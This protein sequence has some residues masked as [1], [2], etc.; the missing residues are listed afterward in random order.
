MPMLS[1]LPRTLMM[2]IAFVALQVS[3]LGATPACALWDHQ[4]MASVTSS[5]GARRSGA[6]ADDASVGVMAA[7]D[8]FAGPSRELAVA[9]TPD[10]K[11]PCEHGTAPERCAVM[12]SCAAFIAAQSASPDEPP[13]PATR[14]ASAIML[15][16]V[17]AAL[18]PELPPPRA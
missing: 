7:N 18:P 5:D 16:P 2:I 15:A 8:P 3:V 17:F 14:V 6:A 9:G 10:G 4:P 12:P 1:R 11:A 13:V